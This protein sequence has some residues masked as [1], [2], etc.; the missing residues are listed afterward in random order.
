MVRVTIDDKVA[1]SLAVAREQV[2]LRDESGQR[3][4]YFLPPAVHERLLYDW[5]ESRIS[6]GEIK[7]ARDEI[8]TVLRGQPLSVGKPALLDARM[9]VVLPL[10]VV[11]DVRPDDRIV[12][13]LLVR[14][15][16]TR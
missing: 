8:D 7:A 6:E 1:A 14:R 12:E 15:V 11:Y 9:L 13:V 5:A 2:E 4:G 10:A 16:P 3:V